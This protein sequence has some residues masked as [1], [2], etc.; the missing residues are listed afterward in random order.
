MMTNVPWAAIW[1]GVLAGFSYITAGSMLADVVDK[2]TAA[3]LVIIT[4][5]LQSGTSAY[6][7]ARKTASNQRE[8]LP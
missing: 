5:G 7:T 2:R 8:A 3:L 1:S 6:Q 4:G